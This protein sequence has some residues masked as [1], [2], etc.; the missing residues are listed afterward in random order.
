[1]L[2]SSRRLEQ[3]YFSWRLT[4]VFALLQPGA[5]R[6]WQLCKVTL[7][8]ELEP[9]T[10]NPWSCSTDWASQTKI[11]TNAH[12]AK[13]QYSICLNRWTS[14]GFLSTVSESA[15]FRWVSSNRKILYNAIWCITNRL[16]LHNALLT[17]YFSFG[18]IFLLTLPLHKQLEDGNDEAPCKCTV[19]NLSLGQPLSSIPQTLSL[20]DW[21]EFSVLRMVLSWYK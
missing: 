3:P 15:K 5:Q 14:R 17:F 13:L 19:S 8:V 6:I 9:M 21:L 7:N 12:S 10:L 20:A 18:L 4:N 16:S 2:E 1:M 11:G